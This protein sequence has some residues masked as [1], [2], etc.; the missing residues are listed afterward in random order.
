VKLLVATTTGWSPATDPERHVIPGEILLPAEQCDTIHCLCHREFVSV[1][2][3][4]RTLHARVVE[5]DITDEQLFDLA[6]DYV[7][8]MFDEPDLDEIGAYVQDL[9]EPPQDFPVSTIVERWGYE[10]RDITDNT[11]GDGD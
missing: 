8:E 4:N 1:T 10:L 6:R 7:V 9:R 2:T 3:Y 5:L 11:M